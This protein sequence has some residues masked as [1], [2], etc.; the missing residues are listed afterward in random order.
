MDLGK[1]D[2]VTLKAIIK[3]IL[4]EDISLFKEVI[5][6]V[7]IENEII[8]SKKNENRAEK[9]QKMID[10]DFDKYDDVFKTLS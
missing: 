1:L 6:E 5:K 4:R 7:L 9:I 10:Q 3:D 2:I 8:K